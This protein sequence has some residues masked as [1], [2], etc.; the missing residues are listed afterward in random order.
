M[1]PG[2]MV[3]S[4]I[5]S[6]LK[7]VNGFPI[8]S[9]QGFPTGVFLILRMGGL[10]KPFHGRYDPLGGFLA[11]HVHHACSLIPPAGVVKAIIW[12]TAL[13]MALK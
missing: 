6:C 2:N 12:P 4:S 13:H 8:C 10:H 9:G 1:E 3:I 11:F 7:V 5:S